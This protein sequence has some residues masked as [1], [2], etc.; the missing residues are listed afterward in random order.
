M[1]LKIGD[2]I[3]I[4]THF[5]KQIGYIATGKDVDELKNGTTT[6]VNTFIDLSKFNHLP[7]FMLWT[8]FG[9]YFIYFGIGGFL[10]VRKEFSLFN[11]VY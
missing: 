4:V 1:I 11:F 8:A 10:H 9:S 5:F 7:Y 3:I 2:W 6:D